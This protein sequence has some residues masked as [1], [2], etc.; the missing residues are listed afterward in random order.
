[1]GEARS[2]AAE[3]MEAT[4]AALKDGGVAE[5]DIQTS[6]FSVQPRYDYRDREEELI[7][8]VVTN[9]VT[10]K[11]R[12]IDDTGDLIDAAVEAGGDLARV[13]DLRFTID[14]P[15]ALED[16]ARQEAVAEARHKAETLAEAAGVD[17]GPVRSISESGGVLPDFYGYG[18]AELQDFDEAVRTSIE[19]GELEVVKQVQIVYGLEGN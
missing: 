11:I 3:A 18:A 1:V 13:H 14:D 19:P 7:G 6:R 10:A 5:E 9:L 16:E 15:S 8:F 4:L 12:N 2:Q 17:L